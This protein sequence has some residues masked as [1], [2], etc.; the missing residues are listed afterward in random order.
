MSTLE[1]ANITFAELL[2][3]QQTFGQRIIM[4]EEGIIEGGQ[5]AKQMKKM[6]EKPC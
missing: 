2:N 1:N 4:R 3:S 5:L 6:N